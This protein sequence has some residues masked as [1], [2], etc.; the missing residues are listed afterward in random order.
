MKMLSDF[1][2]KV[3]RV[4]SANPQHGTRA[5]M[6]VEMIIVKTAIFRHHKIHKYSLTSFGGRTYKQFV[7]VLAD[8]RSQNGN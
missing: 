7:Y 6:K 4:I 1:C 3:E 8:R 2:A 5:H